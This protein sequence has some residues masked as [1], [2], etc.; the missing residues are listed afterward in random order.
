MS[1]RKPVC[2]FDDGSD[3]MGEIDQ[4]AVVNEDRECVL[5]LYIPDPTPKTRK[6]LRLTTKEAHTH[7]V[8]D[9]A[10]T[11]RLAGEE[12]MFDRP[13]ICIHP[14]SMRSSACGCGYSV[15]FWHEFA[16]AVLGEGVRHDHGEE[17]VRLRLLMGHGAVVDIAKNYDSRLDLS[18][19]ADL[20]TDH[21][22]F[23]IVETVNRFTA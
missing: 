12:P 10:R 1:N 7:Y 2:P 6:W 17:W 19:I 16:H 23:G 9:L 18:K 22:A 15:L 4:W 21:P 5:S 8:T 3:W 11:A 13:V 20:D 14:R